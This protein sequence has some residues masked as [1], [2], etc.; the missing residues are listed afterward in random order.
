MK[1]IILEFVEI[2]INQILYLRAIYPQQIFKKC[3]AYSLPVYCSI[4]PPLNSYVKNA[5]IAAKHLIEENNLRRLE[6]IIYKGSEDNI[7]ECFTMAFSSELKVSDSDRYLMELEEQF[8]KSIY[9]LEKRCKL[10]KKRTGEHSKF[11]VLL[12]TTE[13]CYQELCNE[14]KFQ[15][16][17]IVFK[18]HYLVKYS[19]SF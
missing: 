1:N 10:L 17:L 12:Y 3:K 16:N 9:S 8:R 13:S 14:P 5:L 15:V 7:L 2:V 6:L 4:Y 18:T 19:L 11:K